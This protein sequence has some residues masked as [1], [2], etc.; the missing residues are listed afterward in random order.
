MN[1]FNENSDNRY[2][3]DGNIWPFFYAIAGESQSVDEAL[4]ENDDS[5]SSFYISSACSH[6]TTLTNDNEVAVDQPNNTHG[7]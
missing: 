3:S 1:G 4:M 7:K 2:D 6:N 5:N